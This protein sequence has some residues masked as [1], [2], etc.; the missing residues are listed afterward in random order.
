MRTVNNDCSQNCGAVVIGRN[1]GLRLDA[2]FRSLVGQVVSIVYIDSGSIDNSLEI[3]R[4]QNAEIV[5]LD[6]ATPFTAARARNAGFKRLKELHDDL[7]YVQFVDGDSTIVGDW[8]SRAE[9]FLTEHADVAVVCGQLRERYPEHSIYN[10]LCDVEWDMPN[11]E[12]PTSGGIA[13]IRAEAF[14]EV[15]GFRA[16]VIAGEEPELCARLRQRGWTIW[17][18]ENEMA[19]HDAD[20]SSFDQWWRRNVRTGCAYALGASLHG[21]SPQRLWVRRQRSA[22]FWGLILP[23]AIMVG[24]VAKIYV[25]AAFLLYPLQMVRV[26]FGRRDLG[27]FAWTYA[28][29]M[30]LTKFAEMLGIV[31][32][33]IGQATGAE[34]M[35]I[36]YKDLGQQGRK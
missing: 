9:V 13:M 28:G 7:A 23:L 6:L 14:S 32:F 35:I 19:L 4:A 2:C 36:E 1:E 16:D 25:I 27:H 30:S 33:Y 8:V 24:A 22:I 31:R 11:G 17:H 26:A 10:R 15:E 20:I 12:I 29:F 34:H 3:A 21:K 5:E 18:I